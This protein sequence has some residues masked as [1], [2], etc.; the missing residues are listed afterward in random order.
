MTCLPGET[1]LSTGAVSIL[2]CQGCSPGSIM[3]GSTCTPCPSNTYLNKKT[4]QS[5]PAGTVFAGT[6]ATSVSS[7]K[8]APCPPNTFWN[9]A[10]RKCQSCPAGTVFAGT[11]ATSA[12]F[13]KPCPAGSATWLGKDGYGC[14][15]CPAGSFSS[16]PG[17]KECTVCTW[18]RYSSSPGASACTL[19]RCPEGTYGEKVSAEQKGATKPAECIKC[20]A[21]RPFGDGRACCVASEWMNSHKVCKETY[22]WMMKR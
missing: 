9:T 22:D 21:E 5:C 11:G 17:E 1:T 6:G 4:C 19:H 12:S 18:G 7:C 16:K 2:S 13:C 10:T 15:L 20:P 8:P 3:K 14:S